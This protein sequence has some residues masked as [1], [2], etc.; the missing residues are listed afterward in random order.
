MTLPAVYLSAEQTLPLHRRY[1]K[2]FAENSI[3]QIGLSMCNGIG[4]ENSAASDWEG[5]SD[6]VAGKVTRLYFVRFLHVEPVWQVK[7]S[8]SL[9]TRKSRKWQTRN[10]FD[11]K[12]I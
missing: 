3:L 8:D 10:D 1:R 12:L 4:Y 6:C 7:Q 5:W 2:N 11:G 9:L